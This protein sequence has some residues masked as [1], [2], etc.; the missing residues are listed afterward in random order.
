[1]QAGI[2]F[3]EL[4]CRRNLVSFSIKSSPRARGWSTNLTIIYNWQSEG[5]HYNGRKPSGKPGD[6][7]FRNLYESDQNVR[8]KM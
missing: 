1:M 5:I 2:T 6:L 4:D 3:T 8:Y 7:C